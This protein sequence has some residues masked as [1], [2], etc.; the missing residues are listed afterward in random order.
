MLHQ[1]PFRQKIIVMAAV[2]SGLFLVAL[3]QTIIATALGKIVEEF[4][5]FS[6]LSWIV[7]AYLLTTTITVPISGKLSDLFGRRLLLL[8][9]VA[10]FTLGSLLSG[11]AGDVNQLIWFRALQGVGGGILT[12]N[13]FTI[14]GDLFS[15]RERARWQGIIAAV[16]GSASVIGPVLGGYLT[17][18]HAILWFTTSWRW[19]LWINVPIGII[20]FLLIARFCPPIIHDKKPRI[21]FAGAGLLGAALALTIFATDN[22][23]NIFADVLTATGWSL[24]VLRLVLTAII[25][26]LVAA[27]VY[28]E[29]R[30]EEPIIPLRFF[31]N[32]NFRTVIVIS[33]LNGAAFLGAI[34][35]L[36]QFNQQ[37]FDA[38]ASQAGLMILPLVLGLGASAAGGGQLVTKTGKYKYAFIIG[39]AV[40]SVS[41]AALTILQPSSPYWQEAIIMVIA[42]AGLGF[43]LPILNLAVQNEFEQHDL[44]AVTA[45]V[46]L[47][48]SLGS[49]VGTAVFGSM[50]TAGVAA[51][52]GNLSGDP[53]IAQLSQNPQSS[54]FVQTVDANAALRL[55]TSDVTKEIR[56][57]AAKAIDASVLPQP[58]KESAKSDFVAKQD[59][60]GD[61]VKQAFSDS[62]HVVF[63]SASGLMAAAT[64]VSLFIIERKLKGGHDD[65]P[66]LAH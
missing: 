34:L 2:M 58:A 27:F 61:K 37:V 55:N 29:Q 6:S 20:T 54:S 48:R 18:P 14:I 22:T 16:F 35:Y 60:F 51:S 36:T 24:G 63:W 26:A 44:G 53:Y 47:F 49:T 21:D 41:L 33:L 52:L 19:T 32:R 8:I 43:G 17:D 15:P 45:S 50:L 30:A 3:D 31:K 40:T 39:L 13:A 64:I 65:T 23:E 4:N 10:I 42:G 66:G 59:A 12:S 56:D 1:I 7:T 5:S 11:M 25:I 62:L 46:Q 9:G 38:T 28:V 57:G